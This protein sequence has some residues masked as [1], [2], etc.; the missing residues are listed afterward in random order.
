MFFRLPFQS[1]F[2]MKVLRLLCCLALAAA[3]DDESGGPAHIRAYNLAGD[4]I[5]DVAL[6]VPADGIDAWAFVM[7]A[8]GAELIS[9]QSRFMGPA[10]FVSA[11]N[12]A[13]HDLATTGWCLSV[14]VA[15]TGRRRPNVGFAEVGTVLPGDILVFQLLRFADFP[16]RDAADDAAAAA[17]VAEQERAQA[18]AAARAAAREAED[19]DEL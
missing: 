13:K 6:D 9:V 14:E 1:I 3:Q 10:P 19:D 18:E 7:E 11:I 2:V 15:A 17:R 4:I 5:A 16:D 8:K 12:G